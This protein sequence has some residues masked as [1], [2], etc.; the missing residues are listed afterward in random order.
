M[1]YK[2]N[3]KHN[4]LVIPDLQEPYAHPDAVEF[5]RTV[6][7]EYDCDEVVCI[8]DEVDQH[9]MSRFD[10]HPEADGPGVELTKAIRKM[11]P[12]YEEFPDVKVCHSN[13]TRRV[14]KKLFHAGIPKA[15]FKDVA[16][17]MEAPEGWVWKNSW[18]IDG[19]RYEHGDAAG[20][21]NAHRSLAIARMQP[22]VIGHHHASGGVQYIANDTRVIFGMNVGCLIDFKS[23]AFE[24]ARS[25]KYKPTL[26]CGVVLQ[27]TPHFIPMKT[28]ARGRWTRYL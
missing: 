18:E 24:Y 21:I 7:T 19:V 8:G 13:H 28:N 16:D 26:G 25:A 22:V 4:V 17:W 12:Y 5:L 6:G 20:G 27:G 15:Y 3:A 1:R 23:H 2:T 14:Y 9:A 10:P 11:Q